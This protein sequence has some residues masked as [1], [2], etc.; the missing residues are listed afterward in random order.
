MIPWVYITEKNI[1]FFL[2]AETR[3]NI[4]ENGVTF[5]KILMCLV[6]I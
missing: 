2:N 3:K 4:Q 1:D 5:K 6:L